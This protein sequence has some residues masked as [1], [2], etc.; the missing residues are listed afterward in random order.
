MS[1]TSMLLRASVVLAAFCVSGC[2][3]T[4]W[5][6]PAYT[7]DYRMRYP[8]TVAP[9]MRTLRIP[10]GGVG[11]GI[12]LNMQAQLRRFVG[13]YRNA[14]VGAI[15]VSTPEGWENVALE[16]AGHVAQLGVPRDRIV[17]GTNP[18]RQPGSE[19]EIGFVSYKAETKACGDWSEDLAVT[20]RNA[21]SPN[22][23]C[24][25]QNNIAAMVADPRDFIG[26]Q[27]MDPGDTQRRMTVLEKYRA[28]E[29]TPAELTEMQSG[30]VSQAV[31]NNGN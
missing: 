26:P 30:V 29:S 16:F 5:K 1:N 23:G 24:A 2:G 18:T 10:Y 15:S 27:P 20:R 25:T 4:T 21:P 22:L 19:I 3:T 13:E 8:I 11:A 14:G 12:D 17:L 9:E 7:E 31:V 28:G 6:D